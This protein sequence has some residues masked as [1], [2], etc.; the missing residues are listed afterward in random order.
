MFTKTTLAFQA[1]KTKLHTWDKRLKG[2]EKLH[3]LQ[4][5]GKGRRYLLR[6][7]ILVS[8]VCLL[9]TINKR[10]YFLQHFLGKALALW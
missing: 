7:V 6:V 3:F 10:N 8:G 1:F 2:S 9:D 4:A 5:F